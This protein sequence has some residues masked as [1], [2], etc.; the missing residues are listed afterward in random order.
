MINGPASTAIR[1]ILCAFAIAGAGTVAIAAGEAPKDAPT[2]AG[3]PIGGQTIPLGAPGP[4]ISVMPPVDRN[5]FPAEI[6][7]RMRA[8]LVD[9]SGSFRVRSGDAQQKND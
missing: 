1:A 4:S 5:A 2:Q 9:A 7:E 6:M 3:A 8:A